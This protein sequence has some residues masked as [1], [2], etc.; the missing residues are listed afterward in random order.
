MCQ[1]FT[2]PTPTS[3]SKVETPGSIV[4]RQLRSRSK[5]ILTSQTFLLV[6]LFFC[7]CIFIQNTHFSKIDSVSFQEATEAISMESGPKI[8][9]IIKA[10]KEE[11]AHIKTSFD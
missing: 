9:H 4:K 8:L 1:V 5:Q 7:I 10:S 2:P 3:D 11:L 6:F